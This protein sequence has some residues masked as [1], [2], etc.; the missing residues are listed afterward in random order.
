MF[1]VFATVL[2]KIVAIYSICVGAT[3]NTSLVMFSGFSAL[4]GV[5]I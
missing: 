4:A 2:P 1:I 5:R 3:I